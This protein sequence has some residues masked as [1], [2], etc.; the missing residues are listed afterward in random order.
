MRSLKDANNN[1]EVETTKVVMEPRKGKRTR[2]G[3]ELLFTISSFLLSS[4]VVFLMIF[5]EL[6]PTTGI[7]PI[8]KI[9]SGDHDSKAP[10][11]LAPKFFS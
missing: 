6:N 3:V 4:W 7:P 11:T 10:S 1:I 9:F 8:I 2:L 5:F